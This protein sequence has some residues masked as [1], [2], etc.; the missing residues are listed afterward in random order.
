MG[1]MN[2]DLTYR[3]GGRIGAGTVADSLDAFGCALDCI[4]SEIFLD[5]V[6]ELLLG[7]LEML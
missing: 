3:V 7:L 4:F 5:V 6:F 2:G 1:A